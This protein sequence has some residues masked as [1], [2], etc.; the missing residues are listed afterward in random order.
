MKLSFNSEGGPLVIEA[1]LTCRADANRL[2]KIVD[3][4]AY[5]LWPFRA[6]EPLPQEEIAQPLAFPGLFEV[7][8]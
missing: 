5:S 7:V 1:V 8:E 3:E 6:A 2:T 4:L